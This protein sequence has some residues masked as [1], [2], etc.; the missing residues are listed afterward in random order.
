MNSSLIVSFLQHLNT[1]FHCFLPSMVSDKK[2]TVNLIED[3][4]YMISCFIL[5]LSRL[6]FGCLTM[7]LLDVDPLL[8]YSTW[9][10]LSI[11]MFCIK[12]GKHL[13]I[14]LSNI[15]LSSSPLFFFCLPPPS[16][17]STEYMMAFLMVSH[18]F[19]RLCSE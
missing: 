3:D 10:L 11:L 7:M 9:N 13:V 2:S 5:L 18:R 6:S 15:S 14:I 16:G 8:I 12:I 19:L 1:P 17:S 4:L